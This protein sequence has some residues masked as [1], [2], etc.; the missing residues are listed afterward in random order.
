M[1]ELTEFGGDANY[2][3]HRWRTE[4]TASFAAFV[5]GELV[6]TNLATSWGSVGFFGPLSVRPD[7]W[8][9]GIAKRLIEPIMER[10]TQ[11]E[12]QQMGLFTVPN[13]PR[14]HALYQRFGFWP[15]FLTAV[16]AKSVQQL[17][18]VLQEARY[19]DL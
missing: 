12:T 6:G 9:Q 15:R 2:I 11:W 7:L 13:S 4:P 8:N 18:P 19:S 17:E 16:M 1:S 5:D 10:F 3:Q 14:H